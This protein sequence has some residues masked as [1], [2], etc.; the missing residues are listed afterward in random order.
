[1]PTYGSPGVGTVQHVLGA[2]LFADAGV[3]AQ[4]VPYPGGPQAIVDLLGGR[5]S[6]LILPDGLLQPHRPGGSLR[7]LAT[8]GTRRTLLMPDV[9]TAVES[10]F[11]RLV[12]QEWLAWFAARGTPASIVAARAAA[13]RAA[14]AELTPALGELGIEA[15]GSTPA[16]LATQ[17][18]NESRDWARRLA[19]TG[20]RIE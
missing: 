19:A 17:L 14:A 9:P 5:L 12:G 13:V 7:V 6:M 20:I 10:G 18:E 16:E 1:V 11:P 4:H 15:L 8:F 2:T 3:A